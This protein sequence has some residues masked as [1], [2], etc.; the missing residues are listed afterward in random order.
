MCYHSFFLKHVLAFALGYLSFSENSTWK[1]LCL[2]NS[3]YILTT[4][5]VVLTWI[6]FFSNPFCIYYTII[7][8]LCENPVLIQWV[9]IYFCLG[10]LNHV[11][12]HFIILSILSLALRCVWLWS[13]FSQ[14][15]SFSNYYVRIIFVVTSLFFF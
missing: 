10:L 2:L 5:W 13:L 3:P 7:W 4:I 11:F 14:T 6:F 15:H 12:L 9:M 8:N 1:N